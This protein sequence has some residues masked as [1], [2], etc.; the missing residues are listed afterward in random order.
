MT[1]SMRALLMGAALS[2]FAAGTT[3][4]AALPGTDKGEDSG[5][6][7]TSA[8]PERHRWS[9]SPIDKRNDS[10]KKAFK[11]EQGK[12][13]CKGKNDCKGKGGCGSTKGKNTCKGKGE[14]ATCGKMG[15]PV[16]THRD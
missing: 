6:Q 12:H 14:C 5:E 16:K 2:G 15:C 3:A 4:S 11:C 8:Q 1:T 7:A 9:P 13:T 10:G